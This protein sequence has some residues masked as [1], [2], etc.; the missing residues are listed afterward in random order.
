MLL[1]LTMDSK[2][3]HDTHPLH[4]QPLILTLV[5]A[6]AGPLMLLGPTMDPWL[7][8]DTYPFSPYA[9]SIPHPTQLLQIP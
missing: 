2:L 1:G 4:P 5:L 8:H 6:A 9:S 7:V 3:V